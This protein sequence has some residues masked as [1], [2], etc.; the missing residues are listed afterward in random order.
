M[1]E[2]KV[3]ENWHL[4]T[5]IEFTSNGVWLRVSLNIELGLAKYLSPNNVQ[6]GKFRTVYALRSFLESSCICKDSME[7]IH[8]MLLNNCMK[9]IRVAKAKRNEQ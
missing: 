3:K 2:I 9:N 5:S 7:T 1:N 8:N 6:K 4:N